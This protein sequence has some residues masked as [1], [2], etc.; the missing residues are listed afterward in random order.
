MECSHNHK[1]KPRSKWN[2]HTGPDECTM[3]STCFHYIK[4]KDS[5]PI[6]AITTKQFKS[7]T[8]L[9]HD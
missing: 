7:D 9:D 2:C 5:C 1:L 8:S 6:P 4:A 3:V